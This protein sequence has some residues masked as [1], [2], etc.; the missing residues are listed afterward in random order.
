MFK[1]SKTVQSVVARSMATSAR[2]TVTVKLPA[3]FK[4]GYYVDTVNGPVLINNS[5]EFIKVMSEDPVLSKKAFAGLGLEELNPEFV[6][7]FVT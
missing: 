5:D 4:P 3:G 7:S 1:L 2:R 6:S